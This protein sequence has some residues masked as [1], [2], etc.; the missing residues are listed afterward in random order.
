MARLN[1][2]ALQFSIIFFYISE[3]LYT[4]LKIGV[5]QVYSN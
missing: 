2:L 4:F 1:K 3:V 5:M